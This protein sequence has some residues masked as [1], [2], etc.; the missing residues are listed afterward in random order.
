MSTSRT[1]IWRHV[2]LSAVTWGSVLFSALAFEEKSVAFRV[3][4]ATAYVS[5]FFLAA[6]LSVGPWNALRGRRVPVS[7]H[8]RRDFGIWAAFAGLIHVAAGLQVHMRG[9]FWLYF[10][11]NPDAD[12][13]FPI[14]IDAFG[15]VNHA[16]LVA[17][18]IL[19]LLLLLSNDRSIARFGGRTWKRVQR[20]NYLLALLVVAHG[21][22]YQRIESRQGTF[23]AGLSATAA[24]VLS[25]QL[26]GYRRR[27]RG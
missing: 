23:V 3:S 4:I 11:P 17:T 27:V 6:T 13:H 10:L 9:K 7:T 19:I 8:L 5:F 21:V 20:S 1:R 18:V 2:G 26:F 24:V 25:A 22:G 12:T 16:G 14:R 15:W